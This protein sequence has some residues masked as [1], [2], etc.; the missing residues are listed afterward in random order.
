MNYIADFLCKDLRLIIEL[1]GY[2]HHFEQ[3]WKKD[4][5]RQKELEEA[6]F[7]ILR[8]SDD[9]VMND[10]RNVERVIVDKIKKLE[11]RKSPL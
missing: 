4:S 8:F 11:E 1:D 5:Q 9:E 6:G 7:T 3:Q 2:S 10:I